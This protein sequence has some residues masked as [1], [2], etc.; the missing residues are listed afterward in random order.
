MN[1]EYKI[2]APIHVDQFVEV[3]QN[4]GLAE[5]R[6][7]DNL[8]CLAGMLQ[9]SNLLVSA[10][11]GEALVGIARSMTDF[12]YACYLSDLAVARNVQGQGVGKKLQQL[13][14]RQL[15][16][17]CKIVLLAAPGVSDYYRSVGFESSDKCWIL[18]RSK[19]LK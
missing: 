11:D 16:P 4:S 15:G 17:L 7:I 9:N 5:R 12:H 18:P 3:L 2:N 14:Q 1:L 10:W 13:T 8:D 6:P 19:R